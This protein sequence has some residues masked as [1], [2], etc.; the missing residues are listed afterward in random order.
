MKLNQRG[1]TLV[2]V[3]LVILVFSVL[4]F[5][6]MGSVV[7]ENKRTHTTESNM[8]AR[9]LAE[10]GLKYF[11]KDFNKSYRSLLKDFAE[12]NNTKT[13]NL[14]KEK[15][16]NFNNNFLADF[17]NDYQSPTEIESGNI[18]ISAKIEAGMVVVTSTGKSG[19]S[20]LDIKTLVGHYLPSFLID[21][22]KIMYKIADFPPGGKAINF[23]DVNV[24]GLGLFDIL[25]LDAVQ[26]EGDDEKYYPVPN[27][28][29]L[30]VKGLGEILN[31]TIPGGDGFS[32]MNN[33]RVIATREG[34]ILGVG[35]LG[36]PSLVNINL[37][38]YSSGDD[39]NVIIDGGYTI[40][41]LVIPLG[42]TYQD[43]NFKKLAVLGS[44]VIK[45]EHWGN[46]DLLEFL[47]LYQ[48]LKNIPLFRFW[49]LSEI[50]KTLDLP[51][52]L[53]I[54]GIN[55][56]LDILQIP[57]D[58][59]GPRAFTFDES[60]YVNKD[61]IIGSVR[62]R[63]DLLGTHYEPK[64]NLIIRGNIGVMRDLN[65]SDVILDI[66]KKDTNQALYVQGNVMI[67]NAMVNNNGAKEED[68][69]D[70]RVFSKGKIT[71]DNRG[72]T[73]CCNTYRGIF[74]ADKIEFL[75]KPNKKIKIEGAIIG[76]IVNPQ[77]LDYT[78]D[79][80]LLEKVIGGSATIIPK[81]RTF[82]N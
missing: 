39:T 27:D 68:D 8:Q 69:Y 82:Q 9:Y 76:E 2:T 37:F 26:T 6:L 32:T 47:D 5:A 23:A 28:P 56:L 20:Q 44:T 58:G 36:K 67:K 73:D 60:L 15:L 75:S 34:T 72:D 31:I 46:V 66:G 79:D 64:S 12:H 62:K 80:T 35:L 25:T 57:R 51:G 50:L 30:K 41:Q 48:L 29:L 70:F 38:N 45:Q 59:N 61:L 3:L 43:I 65:I 13:N 19:N 74:Y 7:G 11:E 52:V 54:I 22:D 55:E 63:R 53:N 78:Q 81:G 1:G 77:Y 42:K 71:F 16:V 49:P 24:L 18:E 4:G 21:I 33:N 14:T 17:I 40:L 10:S